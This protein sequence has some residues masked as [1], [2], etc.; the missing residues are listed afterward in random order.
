M[1]DKWTLDEFKNITFNDKR[2]SQLSTSLARR[3]LDPINRA[4]DDWKSCKAAYRF[5][6]NDKVTP[7]DILKPHIEKKIVN[8]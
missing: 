5:F 2:F 6:D 1:E 7:Q 3:P 8:H 4:T